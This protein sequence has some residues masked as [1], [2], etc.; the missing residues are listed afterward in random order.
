MITPQNVL[1][2]ELIG[3]DILVSGAANP[4]QRGLSG[5]V[6]DETRNL[7]VIET[8]NGVR[9]IPK[10]H[11]IFRVRLP[12]RETVEIDGSV[13]VLAPE[14]RINLHEKKRIP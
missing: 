11:S 5:R 2:H 3:M 1:R 6:I 12:G 8:P 14:K 9:R 13:M 7:L 4:D 10:M